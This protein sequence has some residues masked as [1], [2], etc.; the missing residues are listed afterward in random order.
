MFVQTRFDE[1]GRGRR[2][3]VVPPAPVRG[4]VPVLVSYFQ[5]VISFVE[6]A[7]SGEP[8]LS[9]LL[10]TVV[11]SLADGFA[12]EVGPVGVVG[13]DVVE[14]DVG[15][16]ESVVVDD[17]TGDGVVA[18]GLRDAAVAVFVAFESDPLDES[19][20][21]V[22]EIAEPSVGVVVDQVRAC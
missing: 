14:V 10:Y 21:V 18:D 22:V 2:V 5:T 6:P 7:T 17:A 3:A 16:V 13:G 12:V 4:H 1:L 20:L 9:H 19:A 15:V 8:R 11:A